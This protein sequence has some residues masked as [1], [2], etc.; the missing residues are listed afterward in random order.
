M[1]LQNQIY[2]NDKWIQCAEYNFLFS[3]IYGTNSIQ[4]QAYVSVYPIITEY[5]KK[6]LQ[7]WYNR[8]VNFAIADRSII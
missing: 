5:S 6:M 3:S 8:N 4:L 7:T 1:Y 2:Y